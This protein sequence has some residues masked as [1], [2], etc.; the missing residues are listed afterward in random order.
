VVARGEEVG[1]QTHDL[2]GGLDG[3]LVLVLRA[4]GRRK[5]AL[6]V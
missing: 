4:E 2:G 3:A 1:E 5:V 6:K